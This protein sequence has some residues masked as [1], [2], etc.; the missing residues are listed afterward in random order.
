MV[1]STRYDPILVVD[2]SVVTRELINRNL[3]SKGF[4]VVEA[5]DVPTAIAVMNKRPIS[6]VITDLKMFGGSGMNLVKYVKE[7]FVQTEVIII[8]GYPSVDTTADAL[9]MGAIAFLCK[10]FTREELFEIVERALTG[11]P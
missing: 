1:R 4:K 11:R 9:Q 5:A 3:V 8:T 6:L 7:N 10:P 2:D